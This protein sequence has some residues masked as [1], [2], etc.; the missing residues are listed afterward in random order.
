MELGWEGHIL[1]LD[2]RT[3]MPSRATFPHKANIRVM[4]LD[5]D[6]YL[7]LAQKIGATVLSPIAHRW[8][9]LGDYTIVDRMASVFTLAL[10]SA[11]N[12][13]TIPDTRPEYQHQ[14]VEITV[15]PPECN[16]QKQA[17]NPGQPEGTLA[18]AGP[19]GL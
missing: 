9:G 1:F 19:G 3:Y 8:Y 10:D 17:R 13:I 16:I 18:E 4:V 2:E 7:N 11:L 12:I 6:D 14:G 5:G 15:Y